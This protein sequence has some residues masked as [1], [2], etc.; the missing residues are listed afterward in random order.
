MLESVC[1]R[2]RGVRVPISSSAI[3]A[4]RAHDVHLLLADQ[5]TA[6]ELAALPEL[7]DELRAAA[8]VTAWRDREL[9]SVLHNLSAARIDALVLKGAA[10]AQTVYSAPYLRP[11]TDVDLLVTAAS[12]GDCDGVLVAS[13]WQ[14]A[15]EP[16][17]VSIA[18]QRH[19]ERTGP[20][21]LIEHLDLHWKI[22]NAVVFAD[23]LTFEELWPRAVPVPALGP[24]ARAPS[25]ADA[26]FLACVHRVAHHRNSPL[27]M[28]LWDIHLLA[29]SLD[30][31]AQGRFLELASRARVRAVCAR[32]L[33][34][35]SRC[36]GTPVDRLQAALAVPGANHEPSAAFLRPHRTVDVVASDLRFAPG[37]VE[38]GRMIREHL[39]PPASYM[40]TRYPAWPSALLPVAYAYRIVRGAPA[41]FRRPNRASR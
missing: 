27:L 17:T 39:W 20:S 25:P 31:P 13:G 29:S 4:A 23:A 32:G 30:E 16:D 3:D 24:S 7:A 9:R 10:L 36:F 35:A 22:S 28:W 40:R 12:V 14:R 5:L 33:A 1:A 18:A 34:L 11:R 15:P 26:L 38:R 2:L 6:E 41:W 19:Y 8:V 37:W 21:G